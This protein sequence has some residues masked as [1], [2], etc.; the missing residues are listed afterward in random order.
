MT[1]AEDL[2]RLRRRLE[3]VKLLL[4]RT[5]RAD[6]LVAV[7][8]PPSPRAEAVAVAKVLRPGHAECAAWQR[9]QRGSE[10][11][12]MDTAMR[13]QP[14]SHRRPGRMLRSTHEWMSTRSGSRR[15]QR[16]SRNRRRLR[17]SRP[18]AGRARPR[19]RRVSRGS[20]RGR[21]ASGRPGRVLNA[22]V[23]S[24]ERSD[25]SA[26]ARRSGRA[27]GQAAREAQS[28]ADA[29]GREGDQLGSRS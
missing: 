25:A 19:K 4:V 20:R 3:R 15:G 22:R 18:C 26:S 8:A 12:T 28:T 7:V 9:D 14:C 24:V 5:A 1:E 11:D 17:A 16:D 21:E 13:L 2:A 27:R 6:R 29:T 23:E 10:A